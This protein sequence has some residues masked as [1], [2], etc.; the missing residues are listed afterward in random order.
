MQKSAVAGER[1]DHRMGGGVGQGADE[2][3]GLTLVAFVDRDLQARVP[4]IEL[5]VLAG[6]VG[7]ALVTLG[8]QELRADLAEMLLQDRDAACV[9]APAEVLD[10]HGRRSLGIV[11]QQCRDSVLVLVEHGARRRSLVGR[12]SRQR[13]QPDHGVAAHVQRFGDVGVGLARPHQAVHLCPVVPSVQASLPPVVTDQSVG[14]NLRITSDR[15][16][17]RPARSAQYS[18]VVDARLSTTSAGLRRKG[19]NRT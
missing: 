3:D 1:V 5:A 10:D 13:P 15:R 17:F 4:P 2:A 11:A 19:G 16:R 14:R 12:R 6:Q 9:T 18:G 8:R 7:R